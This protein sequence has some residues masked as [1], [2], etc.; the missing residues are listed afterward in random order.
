MPRLVSDC[1]ANLSKKLVPERF[2][3]FGFSGSHLG[4]HQRY[5]KPAR[6]NA[7]ALS[8]GVYSAYMSKVVMVDNV[9]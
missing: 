8:V 5:R 2:E 6:F 3:E 7:Y 4:F 1:F 9:G